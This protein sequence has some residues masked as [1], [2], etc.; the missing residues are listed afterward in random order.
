[1]ASIFTISTFLL[2][3][4]ANTCPRRGGQAVYQA[5]ALLNDQAV[6]DDGLLCAPPSPLKKPEVP[7]PTELT[8]KLYQN[9][10]NGYTIVE[11]G[12][13]ASEDGTVS[14]T[15]ALG[16]VMLTQNFEEGDD[17]IIIFLDELPVGLYQL[18]VKAGKLSSTQL[19]SNLK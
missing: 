19:L 2:T 12:K 10:A 15:D 6:Y 7:L 13:K 17:S 8:F 3:A 18:N 1:M 14:L 5:R 9:P 16:R 11:L 4:I